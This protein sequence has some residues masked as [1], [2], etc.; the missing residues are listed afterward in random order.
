MDFEQQKIVIRGNYIIG[1]WQN[2][3]EQL[4]NALGNKAKGL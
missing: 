1:F 3:L 2:S 4:D